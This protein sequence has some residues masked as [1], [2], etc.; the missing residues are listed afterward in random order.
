[1]G[2]GC[3]PCLSREVERCWMLLL[4]AAR[5]LRRSGARCSAARVPRG[6]REVREDTRCRRPGTRLLQVSLCEV[7]LDWVEVGM[8]DSGAEVCRWRVGRL[9]NLARASAN[10]LEEVGFDEAVESSLVATEV[11]RKVEER[12]HW[13]VDLLV[14]V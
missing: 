6:L 12:Q 1:M 9:V 10:A 7:A 4:F 13:L 2:R 14:I 8:V 5:V 11:G 3:H